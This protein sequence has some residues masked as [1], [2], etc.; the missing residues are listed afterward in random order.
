MASPIIDE[1]STNT[2]LQMSSESS[3]YADNENDLE[4]SRDTDLDAQKKIGDGDGEIQSNHHAAEV[5]P[6]DAEKDFPDLAPSKSMEFP[7]GQLQP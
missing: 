3:T 6:S 2:T 1:G 4:A 5:N 7:D